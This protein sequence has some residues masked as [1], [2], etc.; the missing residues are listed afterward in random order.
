MKLRYYITETTNINDVIDIIDK[1]CQ[2]FIKEMRKDIPCNRLLYSGRDGKPDFFIGD[3]RQNR[4]PRN[5]NKEIHEIADKVFSQ[6]FGIKART[7]TIFTTSEYREAD[8]Y[9]TSY[10]IVPIGDFKIVWSPKVRDFTMAI[11]DKSVWEP[12][13]FKE[14]MILMVHDKKSPEYI[15]M[16]LKRWIK[17]NY[18]IGDLDKALSSSNEIML[19]CNQYVAL[20]DN[21]DKESK[22]ILDY[23]NEGRSVMTN[24]E[25]QKHIGMNDYYKK[26]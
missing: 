21:N 16:R 19:H 7:S 20:K 9:G 10:I 2:P 14:T 25:I 6:I 23:I 1:K 11:D 26:P 15:E 3:V 8:Y 18:K 17:D 24:R 4:Q 13:G 22:T 5:T 12:Q